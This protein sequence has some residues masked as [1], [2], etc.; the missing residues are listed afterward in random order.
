MSRASYFL[1]HLPGWRADEPLELDFGEETAAS[2]AE[3]ELSLEGK[4]GDLEIASDELAVVSEQLMFPRM[5]KESDLSAAELRA[6][7][8]SRTMLKTS[9][10]NRYK[11]FFRRLRCHRI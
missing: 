3:Y 1:Q 6:W 2:L 7:T 4:D 8:T 5:K 10:S 11:F 9:G